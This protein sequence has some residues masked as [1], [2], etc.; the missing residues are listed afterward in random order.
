MTAIKVVGEDQA[1]AELA[2]ATGL[3]FEEQPA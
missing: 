1:L 2:Q 3:S